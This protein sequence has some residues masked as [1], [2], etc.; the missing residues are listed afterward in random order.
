ML[1]TGNNILLTYDSPQK[2]GLIHL[3]VNRST[4]IPFPSSNHRVHH[5]DY[6]DKN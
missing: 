1:V 2:A 4:S 6:E 3:I 5:Y